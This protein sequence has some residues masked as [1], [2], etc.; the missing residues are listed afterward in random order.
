MSKNLTE[1]RADIVFAIVL[2]ALGLGVVFVGMKIPPSRFDPLGSGVVP[3]LM[4]AGLVALALLVLASAL[5]SFKIGDGDRLF[6]GL[7]DIGEETPSLPRAAGAFAWTLIY[8]VFVYMAALVL[9]LAPHSKRSYGTTVVVSGVC[10]VGLDL[11]FRNLLSID[12][13]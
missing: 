7:D 12:L 13:P 1:R 9:A 5:T 2:M 10:A 11:V 6:T 8:A 4:G 3:A